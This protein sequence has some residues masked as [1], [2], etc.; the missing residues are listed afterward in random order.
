M[1]EKIVE[2]FSCLVIHEKNKAKNRNLSYIFFLFTNL[3]NDF[4][5]YFISYK[6]IKIY[7][8]GNK[9]NYINIAQNNLAFFY[10]PSYFPS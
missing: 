3:I 4:F 10:F 8:I 1:E 6:D 2:F 7:M 9:K 5:S